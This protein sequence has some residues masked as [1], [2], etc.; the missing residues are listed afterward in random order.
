MVGRYP[1]KQVRVIAL[2]VWFL[3]GNADL[4]MSY[5]LSRGK[6]YE[7]DDVDL[8]S[9]AQ[10][11]LCVAKWLQDASVIAALH[12]GLLTLADP[13]R[14]TADQY[15]M[16]SLLIEFIITQNQKGIAVDLVTLIAKYIR[17]W[18]LR[19]MSDKVKR[20]LVKL[21]CHRS[22]RRRF[23][24]NL[25]REWSLCFNSFSDSRECTPDQIRRKA[26]TRSRSVRHV[27][28]YSCLQVVL[29]SSS[30][31]IMYLVAFLRHVTLTFIMRVF[32]VSAGPGLLAV[33]AIH[34]GSRCMESGSCVREH[35]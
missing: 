22:T 2:L 13:H 21:V 34:G 25:R 17:L 10:V 12:S 8:N 27:P 23:G 28:Y 4:G 29:S 26:S 14:E 18:S 11:T 15:L 16:H 7:L 3:S 30:I 31:R 32:F 6:D 35:G 24:V 9:A 33:G 19:P 5:V 1:P 20:R